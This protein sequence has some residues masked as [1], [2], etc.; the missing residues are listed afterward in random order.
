MSRSLTTT[1]EADELLP[2]V[3]PGEFLVEEYLQPLG[4]T[5]N[6]LAM[7][8]HVP[9]NRIQEI[10]KGQRGITADTALRLARYFGTTPEFFFNLQATYDLDKA[11]RELLAEI[12]EQVHK[13]KAARAS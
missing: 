4:I 2:L 10:V 13:R 12:Q 11:K 5:P 3:T 9:A 7:D 8:L 6:R 1:T